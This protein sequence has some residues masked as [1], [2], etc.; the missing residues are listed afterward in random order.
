VIEEAFHVDLAATFE[1]FAGFLLWRDR[2]LAVD[3][4]IAFERF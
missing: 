2:L 3:A 1:A 4:D